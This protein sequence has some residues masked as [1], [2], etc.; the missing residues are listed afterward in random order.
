[1]KGEVMKKLHSKLILI[2][3]SVFVAVLFFGCKPVLNP[4]GGINEYISGIVKSEE[5]PG[6]PIPGI[7]VTSNYGST[8]T[9]ENGF[10]GILSYYFEN[11]NHL[12]IF[13]DIDGEEN[14]K[15]KTEDVNIKPGMNSFDVVMKK[16][17]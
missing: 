10:F 17:H 12:I 2:I 5:N 9:D 4:E 8:I 7:K 15:F 6:N 16:D 1:M 13:S 14:G 3:L 11:D